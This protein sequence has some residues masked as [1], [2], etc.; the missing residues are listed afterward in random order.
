MGCC[1]SNYN[2][3][4]KARVI[5][6]DTK[7]IHCML[8]DMAEYG[9]EMI[10]C[11]VGSGNVNLD[12]AGK[13]IDIVKD[14]AEAEYHARLAKCLRKEDEEEEAE[15]KYMK[16]KMKEEHADEYKRYMDKYGEDADRK[17]YD[18][19]RYKNGRFAPKG[20]GT[21][22]GY[23]ESYPAM[24]EAYAPEYWR[25]LDRGNYNRMYYTNPSG[26]R[27][28]YSDG[29]NSSNQSGN[30]GGNVRGY[31][32][33]YNDGY[34]EGEKNSK[35]T[36]SR[37]DKAR[38]GYS[39]SKERNKGNTQEENSENMKKLEEVLNTVK[40]DIKEYVPLMSASEKAMAKQKIDGICKMIS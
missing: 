8:E 28:G 2:T 24:M 6:L 17:F 22:K 18:A 39:E 23:E 25:D 38:R 16:M 31:S 26:E 35:G 33:G 7:H 19:W 13:I 14:L 21:R 3:T 9:K 40:D 30:T 37:Y 32:D 20:R 29:R 34:R 1:K 15:E 4:K 11:A 5:I 36:Q 27:T 10:S 12:D